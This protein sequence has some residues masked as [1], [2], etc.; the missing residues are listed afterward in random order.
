LV[1]L[2]DHTAL[3][4]YT[5]R[6]KD[7]SLS[8]GAVQ[9]GVIM[10]DRTGQRLGN[11]QLVSL[12]GTGGFAEVYLGEQ[13]HLK[14][15][16][17]IKV[18]STRL[19]AEE[20]ERFRKEAQTLAHLNHPHIVR[21]LDFGVE[22][23][24]P[25][26][27]MEYAPKGSLRKRYPRGTRLPIGKVVPIVQQVAGALHYAHQQHLI[28]R[29]IKPENL[30]LS[31]EGK[32]LLSD[33]GIAVVS[34]STSHLR[35]QEFAGTVAYSAPEQL[36]NKPQRASDQ[37]AL[38]IVTYEL[39]T[40]ACPFQGNLL[41]IATQHLH[42]PPPPLRR[43]DDTI[44][45]AV[46]EVVLKALAKDPKER[47]DNVKSFANALQQAN[48][49]DSIHFATTQK[50]SPATPVQEQPKEPVQP[51]L[52]PQLAP[53][54]NV[55]VS[56]LD[57]D[58]YD[59]DDSY[60]APA[61][62]D[63]SDYEIASEPQS[64]NPLGRGQPR[65]AKKRASRRNRRGQRHTTELVQPSPSMLPSYK[66]VLDALHPPPGY[67]APYPPPSYPP[68]GERNRH[69]WQPQH[70]DLLMVWWFSILL[71]GLTYFFYE[72]KSGLEAAVSLFLALA[73]L[74]VMYFFA[75]SK[76]Y[77]MGHWGWFAVL[78]ASAIVVSYLLVGLSSI[79][80]NIRLAATYVV[81]VLVLFS[82]IW[83][84]PSYDL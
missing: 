24:A 34:E 20:I 5:E 39:L 32:V 50:G 72:Q 28:H 13:V 66:S 47:F 79:V 48:Q 25:Y 63:V 22:G 40:G 12:I 9:E 41:A 30:L 43:K 83:F 4:H 29:D 8:D 70:L 84:G 64:P 78:V 71:G 45:P 58:P 57:V 7:S 53:L 69:W 73:V 54:P 37:Y 67:P 82:F 60:Y 49:R 80:W 77:A 23:G 61:Y 18:L 14:T 26:L 3:L 42:E 65:I 46:E 75:L 2:L 52:V 21:M 62:K 81:L 59:E 76:V 1:P 6:S 35:T 38:G 16:A 15:Q 11:Y 17:A 56:S 19:S 55:A 68:R 27:V 33:F 74:G 44:S 51:S 10:A 31:E 36:Q